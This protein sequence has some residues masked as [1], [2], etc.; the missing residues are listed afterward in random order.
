MYL[1]L[2]CLVNL[3]FLHC[4]VRVHG[5]CLLDGLSQGLVV[6]DGV[7]V[8]LNGHLLLDVRLSVALLLHGVGRRLDGSRLARDCLE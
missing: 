8:A 2:S 4:E 5:G 3:Y 1:L 6:V 7:A